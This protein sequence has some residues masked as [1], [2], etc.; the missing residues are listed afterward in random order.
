MRH[1][2][3]R[4]GRQHDASGAKS[5]TTL[6]R[7]HQNR[8]NRQLIRKIARALLQSG[9]IY[10]GDDI[11]NGRP[12]EHK[13][14]LIVT[15]YRGMYEFDLLLSAETYASSL[16]QTN[17]IE[18]ELAMDPVTHSE[19]SSQGRRR[20]RCRTMDAIQYHTISTVQGLQAPIVLT[21]FVRATPSSFLCGH[22]TWTFQTHH[23][24]MYSVGITRS[25]VTQISLAIEWTPN[26][27]PQK[28]RFYEKGFRA[29]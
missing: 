6:L 21:D 18:E 25:Q 9:V 8:W 10:T 4:T 29:W 24:E 26:L 23:N 22:D 1:F 27:D 12:V 20:I 3:I 15:P 13:D 17:L 11:D 14:I 28:E 19:C 16:D 2:L 5:H 7:S